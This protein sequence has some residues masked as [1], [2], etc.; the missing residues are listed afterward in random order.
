MI[1]RE[2]IESIYKAEEFLKQLK[3]N[4]G[5]YLSI[6]EY[7]NGYYIIALYKRNG[8]LIRNIQFIKEI[9]IGDIEQIKHWINNKKKLGVKTVKQCL[10][11]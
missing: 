8:R 4:N 5:E 3:S 1:N 9:Y 10:E 11:V 7:T 2:E 6:G